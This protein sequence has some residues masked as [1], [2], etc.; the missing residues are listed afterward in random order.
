MITS[1]KNFIRIFANDG[2]PTGS[3]GTN[4]TVTWATGQWYVC[5]VT[6]SNSTNK[7]IVTL[8]GVEIINK[9]PSDQ[10]VDNS[11]YKLHFGASPTNGNGTIIRYFD[12]QI[13]DVRITQ[14]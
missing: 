1:A 9:T 11:S 3:D 6:Y 4:V 5:E 13:K 2:T 14:F 7:L 10:P 8:D 12:G